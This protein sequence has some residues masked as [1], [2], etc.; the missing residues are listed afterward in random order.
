MP[1]SVAGPLVGGF[2][3]C[4]AELRRALCGA[5]A[6][7]SVVVFA[8]ALVTLGRARPTIRLDDAA[9]PTP[10]RSSSTR[11]LPFASHASEASTSRWRTSR[12]EP[13][14]RSFRTEGAPSCPCYSPS[15]THFVYDG[16]FGIIPLL[17]FARGKGLAVS[18][19]FMWA[20]SRAFLASEHLLGSHR[21]KLTPPTA[22]RRAR[23]AGLRLVCLPDTRGRS[24]VRAGWYLLVIPS[25]IAALAAEVMMGALH[26]M[27]A[28]AAPGV[29]DAASAL[30][31][32]RAVALIGCFV[33]GPWVAV[34]I[35]L[36]RGSAR[37]ARL[38]P[39]LA[40]GAPRVRRLARRS[41]T[42]FNRQSPLRCRRGPRRGGGPTA[43]AALVC[44]LLTPRTWWTRPSLKY[45]HSCEPVAA[46]LLARP[47]AH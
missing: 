19:C 40:T 36:L 22:S 30:G 29:V 37:P 4:A 11:R 17:A 12:R 9:Q 45:P 23:F 21:I 44:C 13:C 7:F 25:S 47:R 20:S 3:A 46:L 31:A 26:K 15:C 18:T 35:H 1:G 5:V 42:W 6:A 24:I 16:L 14:G 27:L 43:A 33:D 2:L 39:L 34:G 8:V 28:K 32:G 10:P 41:P 38:P